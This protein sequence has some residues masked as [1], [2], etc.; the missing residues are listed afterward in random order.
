[1]LD[2]SSCSRRTRYTGKDAAKAALA[3]K[4]I[5]RG[6]QR[7]STNAYAMAIGRERA[8]CGSYSASDTVWISAEGKRAGRIDPDF[9]E[10]AKACEAGAIIITDTTAHRKRAYNIGERQVA[11]FLATKGYLQRR[12][13]VW[14]R[15]DMKCR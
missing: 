5:G 11:A 1:M 2:I 15:Y 9:A 3:N 13:G 6:S 4:Y 8:N 14:C 10:I 12:D 7:S